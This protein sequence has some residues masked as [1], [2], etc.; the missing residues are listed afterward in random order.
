MD[1]RS[2]FNPSRKT[3]FLRVRESIDIDHKEELLG[4]QLKIKS[5]RDRDLF[6]K[7]KCPRFMKKF[8]NR[9]KKKQTFIRA[10]L[11][12]KKHFL[13]DIIGNLTSGIRMSLHFQLPD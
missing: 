11:L 1:N 10:N 2:L 5:M 6:K 4:S 12:E 7:I 13:A 8:K 3:E 9:N